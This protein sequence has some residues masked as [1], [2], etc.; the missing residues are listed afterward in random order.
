MASAEKVH[1]NGDFSAATTTIID[2]RFGTVALL[3]PIGPDD[4]LRVDYEH[5]KGAFG[6]RRPTSEF[7]RRLRG[8]S[9]ATSWGTLEVAHYS[10]DAKSIASPD[11]LPVMPNSTQWWGSRR[12][13]TMGG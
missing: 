10:D 7:R 9:P 4:V 2:Y 11:A 6:A 5:G 3:R 1:L 8:G 13:T 12:A